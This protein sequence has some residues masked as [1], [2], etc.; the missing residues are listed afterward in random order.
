MESQGQME[1]VLANVNAAKLTL[2]SELTVI[3]EAFEEV[4]LK[5]EE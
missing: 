2:E 1:E 5:A 3:K 4:W